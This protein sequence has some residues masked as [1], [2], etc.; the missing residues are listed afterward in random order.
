VQLP[1]IRIVKQSVD[2]KVAANGIGARIG[3][4]YLLRPT[5]IAVILFGAKSRHLKLMAFL[6]HDHNPELA[7]DGNGAFKDLLNILWQRIRG[8]VIILRVTPKQVIAHTPADPEGREPGRVQ[9]TD[10]VSGQIADFMGRSAVHLWF[11]IYDLRRFANT[12]VNRKS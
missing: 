4:C 8:D 1:G 12:S 2:C 10:N 11:T 7:T 3:E 5:A 9:L 6:Q